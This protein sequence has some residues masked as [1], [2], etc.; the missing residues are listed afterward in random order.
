MMLV[1]AVRTDAERVY[2]ERFGFTPDEIARRSRPAA[3]RGPAAADRDEEDGRN[4]LAVPETRTPETRSR[5][6]GGA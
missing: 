3:S 4:L 6:S 5:Y 1:L 2:G